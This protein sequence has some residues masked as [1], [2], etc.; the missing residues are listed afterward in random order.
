LFRL[1]AATLQVPPLR[2]RERELVLLSE[3]FLSEAADRESRDHHDRDRRDRALHAYRWPGNVRELK[4]VMEYFAATLSGT[5]ST[6]APSRSA[7]GR[8]HTDRARAR[9]RAG[10]GAP[11][12]F[13]PIADEIRALEIQA[14]TQRSMRPAAIRRAPRAHRHAAADVLHEDAPIQPAQVMDWRPSSTA[15]SPTARGSPCARSPMGSRPRTVA[16]DR[17]VFWAY[18]A[19]EL[20]DVADPHVQSALEQLPDAFSS[21]YGA[22]STAA[23]PASGGRSLI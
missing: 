12:D 7:S 20:G 10:A 2:E 21:V 5:S 6:R 15:S 22:G 17:A 16:D 3:L 23:S 19:P 14:M 8:N 11:R 9:R 13:A 4:N 1:N 18:V